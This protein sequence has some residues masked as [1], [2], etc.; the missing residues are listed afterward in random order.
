MPAGK[1]SQEFVPIKEIRDGVVVLKDGTLRVAIMA[2]SLNIALKSEDEQ[3]AILLQF[4]SFLNSLDFSVQIFIQ[5]RKLDIR[6]YLALLEERQKEQES[7]LMRVQVAEYI[8]FIKKFIE[9]TNIMTKTFFVIVPYSPFKVTGEG[10]MLSKFF[11][12]KKKESVQE[13]ETFEEH[14]TQLEQ[15][16]SVVKQGLASAGIRTIDLGTEEL[17]ELFYKIFN[18]GEL[19]KPLSVS[20]QKNQKNTEQKK[21][22]V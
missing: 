4:Q 3:R 19:E 6:P 18:P 22:S 13:T 11:P 9:T 5:S 20:A 8:E 2:S 15:R 7:D 21:F 16:A 10:K 1:S 14:R 17:V 12:T